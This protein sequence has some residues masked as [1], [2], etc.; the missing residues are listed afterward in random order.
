MKKDTQKICNVCG[1]SDINII[2]CPNC[3]SYDLRI[4]IMKAIQE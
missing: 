1:Y 4:I 2:E 3:G